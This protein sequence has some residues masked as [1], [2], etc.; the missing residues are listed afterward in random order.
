MQII[1]LKLF[2]LRW[3]VEP[4]TAEVVLVFGQAYCAIHKNCEEEPGIASSSKT[5][6]MEIVGGL[7]RRRYLPAMHS[8][9]AESPK[10]FCDGWDLA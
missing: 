5:A 4:E 6:V 9:G 3:C 7:Q 8:W 1:A 2:S 10:D